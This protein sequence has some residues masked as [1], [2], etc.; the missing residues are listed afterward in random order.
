MNSTTSLRVPS[1][2]KL[3]LYLLPSSAALSRRIF[4]DALPISSLAGAGGEVTTRP[5]WCPSGQ[6][7]RV[8]AACRGACEI[9]FGLQG[10]TTASE[11][12]TAT[13]PTRTAEV[14]ISIASQRRRKY[15]WGRLGSELYNM[16]RCRV[17]YD[18]F[19]L[20]RML[21]CLSYVL[22]VFVDY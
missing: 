16:R 12:N 21:R 13:F 9:A 19:N 7:L 5:F 15:R 4:I 2:G 1:D 8:Q 6:E 10:M 17:F 14:N 11:H 18:A 20:N 3:D 22:S